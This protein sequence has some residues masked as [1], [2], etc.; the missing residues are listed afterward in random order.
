MSAILFGAY[1]NII[2]LKFSS[3]LVCLQVARLWKK[4]KNLI[5]L[6]HMGRVGERDVDVDVVPLWK[7]KL[8]LK[9][10]YTLFPLVLY[11]G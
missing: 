10:C 6:F 9:S 2:E 5:A 3:L 1:F 11:N 8:I 7:L 4:D